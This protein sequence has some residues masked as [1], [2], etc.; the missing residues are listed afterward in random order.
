M[1]LLAVIENELEEL[2]ENEEMTPFCRNLATAAL[3]AFDWNLSPQ[4]G[5]K[6][7]KFLFTC[8]HFIFLVNLE[9]FY[10]AACLSP[11]NFCLFDD[12]FEKLPR[13]SEDQVWK[14]GKK[15]AYFYKADEDGA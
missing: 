15:L 11:A 13:W 10:T 2:A 14:F 1:P 5:G 8:F 4:R 6:G 12:I 7:Y 3:D 9:F